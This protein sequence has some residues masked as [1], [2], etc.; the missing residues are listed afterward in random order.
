MQALIDFEG[1]R[2]W[3]G[4]MDDQSDSSKPA[5]GSGSNSDGRSSPRTTNAAAAASP[6]PAAKKLEVRPGSHHLKG[7]VLAEDS[8]DSG[9]GSDSPGSML[10]D[11]PSPLHE[12]NI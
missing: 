7:G 3:R 9:D 10:V 11:G 5:S 8:G 1:W 2:K 6:S 4:F 12:G